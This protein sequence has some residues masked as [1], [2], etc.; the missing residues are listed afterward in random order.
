MRF[1]LIL[2]ATVLFP[3]NLDAQ[4]AINNDG[5]TANA[6][7]ILD[8][9]STTKG[10]LIPR[11]SQAERDQISTP[12][13][14]LLIYQT[15]NSPGLYIYIGAAWS[16]LTKEADVWG[17]S[18]NNGTDP[19]TDFLGTADNA[20]LRFRLNNKWAGE[21]NTANGNSCIG[22]S[23]GILMS[24]GF[25]NTSFGHQ[26]FKKNTTGKQ[27]VSL[28]YK[29]MMNNTIGELNSAIGHNALQKN[30][31]GFENTAI[32]SGTLL[33][34]VSGNHNT[35]VGA[36]AGLKNTN[37]GNTAIG[38]YTLYNN[39]V[40]ETTAVGYKA[41]QLNLLG[42]YNTAVGAFSLQQNVS[43]YYNTAVGHS[44][45]FTST[46]DWNTATGCYA[47]RNNETGYYNTA[48]G[49]FAMR[50]NST[51]Y[52]NTAVGSEAMLNL[53]SA[54]YNTSLGTRSGYNITTG[55]G[56]TAIGFWSQYNNSTGQQNTAIGTE[57]LAYN[58]TANYNIAIGSY[59]GGNS[60]W[61]N[62]VSVGNHGYL[63]GGHNQ[64]FLGNLSTV[65]NGGN[66]GW[67]TYSDARVKKDIHDDVVGLEF[68]NRLRAVTYHRDID[69][70]AELTGN[71][72]KGDYPQLYDIEQIKFSGFLAQEVAQAAQESNYAFS[73]I[74]FPK[75]DQE[76]YTLSYES[77]VVPLVKAV[78][79]QQAMIEELKS[80]LAEVEKYI[81]AHR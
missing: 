75:N 17:T 21:L 58:Y 77:F 64:S 43:G 15:D 76:L 52:S 16:N 1:L 44:A 31:V 13:E 69:V 71:Q 55:G 33:D 18:G 51:G 50:Y 56:N 29:S 40:W 60:S 25:A 23:S 28:G 6:S 65:W 62:T 48:I 67:S 78:Q 74:T 8:L 12:A 20:P 11:M 27:N 63:N 30:T 19:T 9:K 66:V 68:I 57:A 79:E 47:L 54:I 73:G 24:T 32:G 49:A 42:L 2:F 46:G 34:N 70:Q 45:L 61:N 72:L 81:E 4:V 53:T 36:A 14:G 37:T 80:K 10:L 22:D 26:S 41:I 38:A 59:S 7:A 5:S 39:I 3:W 35:A